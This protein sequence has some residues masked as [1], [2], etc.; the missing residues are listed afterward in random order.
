M[1]AFYHTNPWT[2]SSVLGCLSSPRLTS[3]PTTLGCVVVDP[4]LCD[5][6]EMRREL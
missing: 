1:E 6:G 5:T 3:R 2:A 4:G